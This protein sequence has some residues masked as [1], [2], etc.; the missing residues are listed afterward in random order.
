MLVS[1]SKLEARGTFATGKN[2]LIETGAFMPPP[3]IGCSNA[4]YRIKWKY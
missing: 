3:H 4:M 2:N 1:G